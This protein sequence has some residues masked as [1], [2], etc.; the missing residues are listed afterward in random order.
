MDTNGYWPWS[1]P[2]KLSVE[3]AERKRWSSSRWDERK[4]KESKKWKK[5][6]RESKKVKMFWGETCSRAPWR[7][8]AWRFRRR[9]RQVR[10]PWSLC[11]CRSL[12]LLTQRQQRQ[13]CGVQKYRD[14]KKFKRDDDKRKSKCLKKGEGRSEDVVWSRRGSARSHKEKRKVCMSSC[15]L[16]FDEED[17]C[18][19]NEGICMNVIWVGV[20]AGQIVIVIIWQSR[21]GQEHLVEWE[22]LDALHL[23]CDPAQRQR[24]WC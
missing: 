1:D 24:W 14:L 18:G 3:L 11:R 19:E 12:L 20:L 17:G 15:L 9:Q 10:S 16:G 4:K 7:Q 22:N 21:V 8:K 6:G 2:A 5:R 13:T 23:P